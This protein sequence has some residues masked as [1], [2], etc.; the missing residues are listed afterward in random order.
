[1]PFY[2]NAVMNMMNVA[3][4]EDERR[5]NSFA[6]KQNWVLTNLVSCSTMMFLCAGEQLARNEELVSLTNDEVAV[7][8][9]QHPPPATCSANYANS[10]GGTTASQTSGFLCPAAR[11]IP[12]DG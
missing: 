7:A 11:H 8:H 3:A 6:G 2:R 1:M 12:Q 5:R 9:E 10:M 4:G